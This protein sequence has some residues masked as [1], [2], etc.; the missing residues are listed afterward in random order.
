MHWAIAAL[1]LLN[2]GIGLVM[3]SLQKPLKEIFVPLHFSWA[4]PLE[5]A[6]ARRRAA[7]IPVTDRA[8]SGRGMP[9]IALIDCR[10]AA[11]GFR[12]G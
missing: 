5:P 3:E 12:I 9:R 4:W 10:N 8:P 1:I 7:F 11:A 2:I 6:Q